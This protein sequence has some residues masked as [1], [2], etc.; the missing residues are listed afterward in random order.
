MYLLLLR[1]QNARVLLDLKLA[2]RTTENETQLKYLG[3]TVTNQNL[4][5]KELRKGISCKDCYHSIQN[6]LSSSK[7][8]TNVNIKI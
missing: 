4:I 3:T 8:S 5:Q 6:I 7:V 2:N 1:H